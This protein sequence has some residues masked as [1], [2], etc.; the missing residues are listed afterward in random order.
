MD[1]S[2]MQ[3]LL[4]VDKTLEKSVAPEQNCKWSVGLVHAQSSSLL[5]IR[6]QSGLYKYYE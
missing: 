4:A 1:C 2:I 5:I 6:L 3:L